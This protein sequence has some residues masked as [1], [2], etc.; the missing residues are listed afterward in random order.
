MSDEAENS[1][2]DDL[3]N[4]SI[5]VSKLLTDTITRL[6][7]R[8]KY[9]EAELNLAREQSLESTLGYLRLHQVVFVSFGQNPD[10]LWETLAKNYGADYA[11]ILMR[12][13]FFLDNAPLSIKQK[14]D[15]K[16][17]FNGGNTRW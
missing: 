3:K 6:E 11:H 2:R 8:V 14:S 10:E 13:L 5:V 1:N 15:L 7:N 12:H 17:A 4:V 16:T 9:L